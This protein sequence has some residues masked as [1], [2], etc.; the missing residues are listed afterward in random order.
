MYRDRDDTEV[1]PSAGWQP[2]DGTINSQ[3]SPNGMLGKVAHPAQ[4]KS[5]APERGE[6][7]YFPTS[8]G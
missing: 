8:Y 5:S 7:R 4:M 2:N 6:A 1:A 3:L